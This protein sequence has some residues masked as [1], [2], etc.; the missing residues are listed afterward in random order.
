MRLASRI[1]IPAAD[2]G[3]TEDQVNTYTYMLKVLARS[4][5]CFICGFQTFLFVKVITWLPKYIV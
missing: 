3:L 1:A 2:K 5:L 4:D